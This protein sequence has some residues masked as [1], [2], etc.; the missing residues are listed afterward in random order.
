MTAVP[1][2]R[3]V[4]PV[5]RYLLVVATIGAALTAIWWSGAVSPRAHL[6]WTGQ[7][8]TT[9]SHAVWQTR[10]LVNPGPLPV[11]VSDIEWTTSG[12]DAPQVRLSDRPPDDAPAAIADSTPFAPTTLEA[13][14]RTTI[15]LAGVATCIPGAKTA[16]PSSNE[17]TVT[18]EPPAGPTTTRTQ[19]VGLDPTRGAAGVEVPCP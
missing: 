12:I 9:Q 2:T 19:R 11:R 4:G 15:V 18:L 6:L 5:G 13:G 3:R 7:G 8:M 14:E 16:W 17:L 10:E 1:A